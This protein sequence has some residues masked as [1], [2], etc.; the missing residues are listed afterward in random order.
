[1]VLLLTGGA[2]QRTGRFFLC[3]RLNRLECRVRPLRANDAAR[4]S[5]YDAFFSVFVVELLELSN[6]VLDGW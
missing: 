2:E 6:A 3:S 4:F 5:L 1:M